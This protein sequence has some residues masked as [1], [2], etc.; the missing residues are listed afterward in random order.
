MTDFYSCSDDEEEL[1][2]HE[3]GDAVESYLNGVDEIPDEL[4]VFAWKRK[5]GP[6]N[7]TYQLWAEWAYEQVEE[8]FTEEYGNCVDWEQPCTDEQK[9]ALIDALRLLIGNHVDKW[10]VWQCDRS[11]DGDI[12]YSKEDL[13]EYE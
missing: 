2:H 10:T 12:V 7:D 1:T 9:K 4:T 13:K 8:R 5:E 11:P 6:L 3:P